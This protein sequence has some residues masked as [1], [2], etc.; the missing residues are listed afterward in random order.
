MSASNC[1]RAVLGYGKFSSCH[2]ST[3]ENH[4]SETILLKCKV[5]YFPHSEI[6]YKYCY[7]DAQIGNFL[8]YSFVC[9]F[10]Q[11]L[12]SVHT[13]IMSNHH[14]PWSATLIQICDWFWGV[15]FEDQAKLPSRGFGNRWILDSLKDCQLPESIAFKTELYL[16]EILGWWGISYKWEGWMTVTLG[17]TSARLSC[18][19]VHCSP[20]AAG[21]FWTYSL[22][23][24]VHPSAKMRY[25]LTQCLVV[26]GLLLMIQPLQVLLAALHQTQPLIV[27]EA[28]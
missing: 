15:R 25:K 22:Y 18:L 11:I 20:L 26:P 1:F 16:V 10:L 5:D 6:T 2:S 21:C 12:Q 17:G 13:L 14:Q 9:A 24:A 3:V 27:T 23:T 4:L 28:P 8:S 7:L 19:T